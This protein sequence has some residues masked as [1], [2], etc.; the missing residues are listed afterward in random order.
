VETIKAERHHLQRNEDNPGKLCINLRP[1]LPSVARSEA[2]TTTLI[3]R[4]ITDAIE[5]TRLVGLKCLLGRCVV[6]Y[7]RY[8]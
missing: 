3:L 8:R 4:T 6:Y 7:I 2:E 5:V 1:F